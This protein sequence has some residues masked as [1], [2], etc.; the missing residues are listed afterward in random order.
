MT[1]VGTEVARRAQQSHD[2][3]GLMLTNPK[4]TA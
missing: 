2:G 3:V 1:S 4:Q